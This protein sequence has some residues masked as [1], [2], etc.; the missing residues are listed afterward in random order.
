MNRHRAAVVGC[1]A[2]AQAIHLPN[3]VRNPRMKLTVT[4]DLDRDAAEACREKFGAKR[5]ETDWQRV[6]DAE[7]VDLIMLA[8]HTNL[9]AGLI[10]PALRAHKPVYVE[11]PLASTIDEMLEIARAERKTGVPVCV[12][13][14]RRSSPAMLEF[15]RLVERILSGETATA[16][17]MDRSHGRDK[18]PE[19]NQIQF[20]IRINDDSRSWKDWIFDDP[21][22]IMFAEMVHFIDIAL[23]LQP[24]KPV[25]VFAEGSQRGNF[26]LVFR[27]DDG[28]ITTIHHTMVGHFDY[29]KELFELTARNFTVVMEQHIEIRQTGFRDE[30]TIKTF[31]YPEASSWVK[32]KGVAGYLRETRAEQKRAEK[33][34]ETPRWIQV[35]KGHYQH[36][37]RFLTHIEGGGPNPCSVE[38]AIQVTQLA[39]RCLEAAGKGEAV[40]V[41]GEVGGGRR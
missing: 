33:A 12:G 18:I 21:Q 40:S 9:R 20:L 37:D 31:G 25:K 28:S 19:E 13:H 7:D 24:G 34:N 29:P 32:R 23:W 39:L 36:L 15:K 1:G 3:V 2:I 38:S 35:D 26:V 11:K 14:N 5:A 16:P 10:V 8:T 22:G 41:G 30:P 4:C 27:F 6:V 17:S